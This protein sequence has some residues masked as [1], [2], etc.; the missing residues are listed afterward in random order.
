M[1]MPAIVPLVLLAVFLLC[2]SFL[3]YVPFVQVK[4]ETFEGLGSVPYSVASVQEGKSTD[5]VF[6]MK[7]APAGVAPS[8]CSDIPGGTV[9]ERPFLIGETE[10]TAGLW[11]AVYRQSQTLGYLIGDRDPNGKFPEPDHPAVGVSWR[12]TIVW[13]NALSEILKL[14]PVYYNDKDFK[15]VIRSFNT[16]QYSSDRVYILSGAD[17]FRL[18]S[19]A[20]WE[21][22]ARY[23]D[24]KKWSP[25][26]HPSGSPHPY[27]STTQ[28]QSYAIYNDIGT[29]RV[30]TLA[31]NK[32]G[33]YDMSGNVWE[34]CFDGFED[35]ENPETDSIQKRV[36]RGGSWMS[37]PYRLQIGGKFGT[38]SHAREAGQGFRLAKNA[39]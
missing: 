23:I 22:A 5:F 12:D 16:L 18:P 19:S 20:E 6:I 15:E 14:T 27:F 39:D 11:S 33:I 28:T 21:L 34:W 26:G 35:A 36:V 10:V 1:L 3:S 37:I 30:K 32:L 9:V 25:G 13:C 38:L 24:G 7:K 31:S 17:G 2:L 4:L 29:Q 8:G